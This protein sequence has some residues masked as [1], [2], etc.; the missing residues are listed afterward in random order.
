MTREIDDKEDTTSEHVKKIL[1]YSIFTSSIKAVV[2]LWI[3]AI[4]MLTYSL[5]WNVY[6]T[7]FP[8]I[9][10]PINHWNMYIICFYNAHLKFCGMPKFL[11]YDIDL[12]YHAQDEL[13]NSKF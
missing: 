4:Q 1:S 3:N 7:I 6:T 11:F 13:F 5:Q 2:C 10:M 12:I 9:I 8:P